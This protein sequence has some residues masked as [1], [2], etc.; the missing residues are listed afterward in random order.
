MAGCS[1]F[2]D[3]MWHARG[4]SSAYNIGKRW[5]PLQWFVL[6]LNAT[7]GAVHCFEDAVGVAGEETPPLG[8][9]G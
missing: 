6:G 3:R 9:T 2:G 7:A 8:S 5:E 1:F 4:P